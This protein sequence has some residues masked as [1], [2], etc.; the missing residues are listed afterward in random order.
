ME[1]S[2]IQPETENRRNY[3]GAGGSSIRMAEQSTGDTQPEP[4]A[5]VRY[6]PGGVE[7]ERMN[8]QLQAEGPRDGTLEVI[9]SVT[10]QTLSDDPFGAHAGTVYQFEDV[11]VVHVPGSE[12][13]TV[14]TF[15]GPVAEWTVEALLDRVRTV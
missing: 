14:A 5:V 11:T 7:I 1:E 3:Q 8:E 13:G 9:R 15:E 10:D 2:A 4:R 12:G 6:G